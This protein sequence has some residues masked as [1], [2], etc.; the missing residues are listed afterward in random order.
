MH[1]ISVVDK[2]RFDAKNNIHLFDQTYM[3]LIHNG[4]NKPED[5]YFYM[6]LSSYNIEVLNCVY[7]YNLQ[8]W[9]KKGSHAL[10]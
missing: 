3:Y 4:A 8:A 9:G 2:A 6:P 5:T 7:V 10:P 1:V